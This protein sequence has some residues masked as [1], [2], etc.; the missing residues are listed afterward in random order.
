MKSTAELKYDA[1]QMLKGR[2]GKAI[3]L[4]LIPTL[5]GLALVLVILIPI[6]ILLVGISAANPDFWSNI[7]NSAGSSTSTSGNFDFS[8]GGG[9]IIG[10]IIGALFSSGISWTYLDLLRGHRNDIAPGPD[11][12]RAFRGAFIGGV[13]ALA[14][15]ITIF[16]GLWS[17]LFVIPGIVKSY[18][19]S[20]SYFIYYDLLSETGQAPRVLDT[21]TASRRLMNGNKGRLFWLDLTFIGWH[22][23]ALLTLGIG[24]LWLNPYIS[25]TKAAFYD[26][27]SKN[28]PVL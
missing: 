5:I 10:A 22:L 24:Y 6:I 17:L 1:K 18:S 15:L 14:V 8:S 19:Y 3:L 11:A 7:G 27:L 25:A 4:N 9:G 20:Q 26:D 12:F 13:I 16:T 28:T 21:I 23:L 2:W